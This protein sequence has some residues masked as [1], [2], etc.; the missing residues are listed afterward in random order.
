M[1]YAFVFSILFAGLDLVQAYRSG[2]WTPANP[3]SRPGTLIAAGGMI[4]ALIIFRQLLAFSYQEELIE[5]GL[6]DYLENE[7]I[8]TNKVVPMETS[9]AA[10]QTQ[11]GKTGRNLPVTG[12][13]SKL[14]KGKV[15]SQP[16]DKPAAGEAKELP[17]QEVMTAAG[18]R[19]P[20]ERCHQ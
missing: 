8:E 20:G 5:D 14:K 10:S 3:W 4:A 7:H 18:Q 9:K 11:A 16:A 19:H 12:K 13:A 6:L 2:Q 1:W 17:S 15:I